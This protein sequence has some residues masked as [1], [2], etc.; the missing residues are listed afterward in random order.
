VP[1]PGGWRSD[2]FVHAMPVEMPVFRVYWWGLFCLHVLL[3][4]G[5]HC[6][7][8]SACPCLYTAFLAAFCPTLYVLTCGGAILC[9]SCPGITF[10]LPPAFFPALLPLVPSVLHGFPLYHLP[11]LLLP[12]VTWNLP[13]LESLCW[14][15]L[16]CLLQE[17]TCLP[18]TY[19]T[20]N[21]SP[22][23]LLHLYAIL[24]AYLCDSCLVPSYLESSPSP[25]CLPSILFLLAAYMSYIVLPV[26]LGASMQMGLPSCTFYFVC[27]SPVCACSL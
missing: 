19:C 21:R 13:V 11:C 7:G 8:P 27:H 15:S 2:A 5:C 18:Y 14:R 3:G 6:H 26:P 17:D 25:L 20:M 1:V 22:S 24:Y 4:G 10:T 16:P 12:G 23:G 9:S